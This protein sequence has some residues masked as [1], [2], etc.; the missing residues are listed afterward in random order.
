M[1]STMQQRRDEI[2]AK[3]ARL[4]EIKQQRLLRKEITANRASM[5]SPSELAQP[6]PS[7]EHQKR[8]LDAIINSVLGD[9]DSRP[10]STGPPGSPAGGRATR[11][12]SVISASQLSSDNEA[13]TSSPAPAHA[14]GTGMV[15]RDMQTLAIAPLATVFEFDAEP[16]KEII[17]YSKGVQT[18]T[19]WTPSK[20][21]GV[22]DSDE[23]RDE[24]PTRTPRASKRM[25][26][27]Q[28]ER[29]D[30]IRANI[31][32]E[33]EEEQKLAQLS[34]LDA[35]AAQGGSKE[36][37]PFR[38]LTNEELNAVQSS[39]EFFNFVER[40]TKVLER[41]LDQ[42]YDI[43]ADYALAGAEVDE[44]DEGYG[45][46]GGK[47][48]R[49]IKEVAQFWD[50]RWSKKR[51]VS[52][53]GFSTK[54]PE[55]V[56]ASYTKNPS[57]PHDPDG[58]IQVWNMHMHDRPEYIFHAQSDILT[59]KFSPFHPNLIIGGA[60]SGQVLLWD[61]RAKSAPVQ[62]TPL[63]GSGHTHP[64][65]SLDIVG[66][67]NANNIISCS[68]DGVVCGWTVDMLS[69]PQEFLELASPPPAKTDDMAVTCIAFPQSDP[70]YFL[71]GT[72]EGSIYPCHR[73][74]RA[75]AKAGV[76]GR[77]KYFG[78]AAPVMSLDFHPAKGAIDLGDLVLSSSVDWSVKL[79]KVRPPAATGGAGNPS[80]SGA[81]AA[82]TVTPLLDIARED[83][84]YDARW[85]PVKPSVFA[86]VDGAGS[87]E[88]WDLNVDV[89]VP[90]QKVT[91][92]ENQ[93]GGFAGMP[94]GIGYMNRSL[95]KVAWERNEGRKVA[96]GGMD[97]V[98][99]VFEVGGDLG[100][101]ETRGEEWSGVKRLVG[102][103]EGEGVK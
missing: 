66:T 21:R 13:R 15:D 35:G 72:E 96:V 100:G 34:A 50:E 27:R 101:T 38:T 93:R 75:G 64:V 18:S 90:V 82:Q 53:L 71:A 85:S 89:E 29:D 6:T 48:G 31:R 26:R 8:D 51:M 5:G 86:L 98:V 4:A 95:N 30:E 24:S 36:N 91:P 47:K 3:R 37:F 49:R 33:I 2:A 87:L 84:V 12:T 70:T 43:L 77:V 54:F 92:S 32:K 52:D 45:S 17:T 65:Y 57:A 40:S 88:I 14:S 25:S 63:T 58:L 10:S 103:L 42:Q 68:T 74:D 41:A 67:Q 39:D 1:E 44:E 97:G 73:Y 9:K 81:G 55:L 19:D 76:D 7:R 83:L 60:Y 102:R 46:A 23:E 11:P 16:K 61:T 59:A 28:K 69:Q 79:W 78:H 99:T 22:G 62:K 56:L 94:S 80:A 20:S